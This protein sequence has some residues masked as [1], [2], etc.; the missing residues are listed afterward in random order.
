MGATLNDSERKIL[1]NTTSS[2]TDVLTDTYLSSEMH[3]GKK[4]NTKYNLPKIGT[5]FSYS[6]TPGH[7]ETKFYH[8]EAKSVA[9]ISLDI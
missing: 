5:N 6:Y 2:G 9:N 3:A 1:T 7:S 4:F 8:W